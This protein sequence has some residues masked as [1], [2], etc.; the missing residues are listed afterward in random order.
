MA[1]EGAITKINEKRKQPLTE[2]QEA[3]LLNYANNGFTDI[4]K[5]FIDAGY[6][7]NNVNVAIRALKDEI[8]E[9][10]EMI[11]VS[12]APGAANTLVRVMTAEDQ[13]PQASNKLDAAKTILDRIGLGKKEQMD[14]NHNVT[15]GLMILPGKHDL[16]D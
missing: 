14:V 2:L 13:V 6:S 10:A 3:A 1:G 8:L 16:G 11:L 9:M 5:A 12:S 15:G 4:R 7:P